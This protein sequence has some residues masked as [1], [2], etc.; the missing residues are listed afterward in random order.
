[1][2]FDGVVAFPDTGITMAKSKPTA[3][4]QM[5]RQVAEHL[6]QV[7][8]SSAS[9]ALAYGHADG[10]SK[11]TF[12]SIVR[13][14]R[15]L[16]SARSNLTVDTI[17]NNSPRGRKGKYWSAVSRLDKRWHKALAAFSTKCLRD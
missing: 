14:G 13:A 10:C 5:R 7:N 12:N 9:K 11:Q 4:G 16:A 3:H 1:M 2:L 15:A 17:N 8:I 6:L